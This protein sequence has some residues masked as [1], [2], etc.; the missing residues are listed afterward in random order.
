MSNGKVIGTGL[1]F[2]QVLFLVFLVLKLTETSVVATWSWW[3]I[4]APLWGGVALFFA[5]WVL[6]MV[7]MLIVGLFSAIGYIISK[8]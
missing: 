5:I 8:K 3:W 2:M 4:T 6:I 7:I 1:T